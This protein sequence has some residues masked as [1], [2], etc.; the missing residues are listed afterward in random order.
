MKPE[1]RCNDRERPDGLS[2]VQFEPE[3]GG[4]VLNASEEGLAFH[5]AAAMPHSGPIRVCISPNPV[6][7]IELVAEIAWMGETKKFGGLRFRELTADVRNQIR[8]WL[9]QTS[10]SEILGSILRIRET[11]RSLLERPE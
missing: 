6:Q 1:R 10:E 2:Y 11:D 7:R 9:A 3:G 8:Q 4:I 5:A